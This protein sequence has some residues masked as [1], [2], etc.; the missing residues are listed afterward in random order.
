MLRALLEE[1]FKLT[2]HRE[3]KESQGYALVV[4]KGGPKL[5]PASASPGQNA[6][7]PGGLQGAVSRSGL[8]RLR[9]WPDPSGRPV[10]DKTGIQGNYDI[11]LTYARDGTTDSSRP[12]IF[13][14]IQEQLGLKLESQKIPIEM[15]VIDRCDRVPTEN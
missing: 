1:R 10:I 13:T 11:Q 4:A 6:V 12:S 15:L 2:T 8:A 3:T 7:Y 9:H 5:K 14:A